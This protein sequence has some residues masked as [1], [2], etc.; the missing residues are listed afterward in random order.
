MGKPSKKTPSHGNNWSDPIWHEAYQQCHV[1]HLTQ[2]VQGMHIGPA[3]Y[4]E[5]QQY[6]Y[7]AQQ[8]D[9]QTTSVGYPQQPQLPTAEITGGDT[10]STP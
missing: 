8:G 9:L 4:P 6:A 5:Q 1:D 3:S 10:I 2:G 7:P